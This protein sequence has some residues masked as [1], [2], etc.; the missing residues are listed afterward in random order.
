MYGSPTTLKAIL[1]LDKKIK[2]LLKE[3]D[4]AQNEFIKSPEDIKADLC[5]R[6]AHRKRTLAEKQLED[7]KKEYVDQEG[8]EV[9]PY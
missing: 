8:G 9:S 7:M 2:Q 4:V 5:F 3:E 6:I 1:I